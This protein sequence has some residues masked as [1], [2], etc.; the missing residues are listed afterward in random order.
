MI[1]PRVFLKG[2]IHFAFCISLSPSQQDNND[3]N[4][5]ENEHDQNANHGALHKAE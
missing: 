2:I 3:R 5:E 4:A 1:I